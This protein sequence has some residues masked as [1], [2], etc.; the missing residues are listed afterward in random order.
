M[1]MRLPQL[2]RAPSWQGDEQVRGEIAY[3]L[4]PQSQ[5]R[6]ILSCLFSL[7][8][9]LLWAGSE[10]EKTCNGP[11]DRRKQR[12]RTRAGAST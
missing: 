12:K 8:R 5:F 7:L 10:R 11:G 6:A 4:A 2:A 3:M 9:A 1:R